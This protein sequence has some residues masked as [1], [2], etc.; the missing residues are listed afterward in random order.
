M[1]AAENRIEILIPGERD[2]SQ[3]RELQSEAL[4]PRGSRYYCVNCRTYV[5]GRELSDRTV[6]DRCGSGLVYESP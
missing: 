6:C 4:R 2:G 5:R 3:G 1:A